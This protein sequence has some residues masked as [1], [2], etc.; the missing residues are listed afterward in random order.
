MELSRIITFDYEDPSD[1]PI[2]PFGAK[3]LFFESNKG[4]F[5]I[6][7]SLC[8]DHTALFEKYKIFLERFNAKPAGGGNLYFY[9]REKGFVLTERSLRYGAANHEETKKL[10]EKILPEIPVTI[11]S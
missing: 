7:D 9:S 4:K 11:E 6:A 8:K 3:Y 10:L 2:R 1:P 5:F